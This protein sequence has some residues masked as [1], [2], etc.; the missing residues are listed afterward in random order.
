MAP[1]LKQPGY[2]CSAHVCRAWELGV[3]Q[4]SFASPSLWGLEGSENAAGDSPSPGFQGTHPLNL[5]EL[6]LLRPETENKM[7]CPPLMV[8]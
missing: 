5:S 6:W 4:R 1:K 2:V 8:V 3:L 7:L